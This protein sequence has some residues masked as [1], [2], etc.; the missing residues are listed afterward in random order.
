MFWPPML[1]GIPGSPQRSSRL[2]TSHSSRGRSPKAFDGFGPLGSLGLD[3]SR[4]VSRS[5][6]RLTTA[7]GLPG[8][9]NSGGGGRAEGSVVHYLDHYLDDVGSVGDMYQQ[10]V[11]REK[12]LSGLSSAASEP[13]RVDTV[14]RAQHVGRLVL[15]PIGAQGFILDGYEVDPR[16][17]SR[18]GT[19]GGVK[20]RYIS[21]AGFTSSDV[22]ADVAQGLESDNWQARPGSRDQ[23]N[24]SWFWGG[25]SA[26]SP[27]RGGEGSAYLWTGQLATFYSDEPADEEEEE[28]SDGDADGEAEEEDFDP[29]RHMAGVARRAGAAGADAKADGDG[30]GAAPAARKKHAHAVIARLFKN[31][32]ALWPVWKCCL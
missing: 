27:S 15:T 31:R 10:Y 7:T 23:T 32:C 18:G 11:E 19:A 17:P 24:S 22:G 14:P 4:A 3:S 2:G 20:G 30:D 25:G 16:A 12:L 5:S 26:A 29:A 8:T 21:S 13:L 9:A 28:E 6:G 1:G